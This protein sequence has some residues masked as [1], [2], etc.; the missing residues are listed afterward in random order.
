MQ[1]LQPLIAFAA[2]ARHASF[3]AAARE[4]GQAP[5]TLAKAVARLEANLGLQLF[6]R[7][8]RQVRL[9]ADGERLYQR[10]QRVLDELEELQT[11]AS[12]SRA[13]P[14][15]V[16]RVAMPVFYGKRFVLPRLAGLLR[17][18]PQLQ[19]DARLSDQY[20]DIVREGLDLAVRIGEL[21][22]SSLV[23][24]RV[25]WQSLC[26]CASP[27]YLRRAGTPRHVEDLSAHAAVLF[28]LPSSGRDR[29][30][31]LRQRGQPV[32]LQPQA[33]LRINET[34][35]VLEALRLG[36]GIAQ[37]PDNVVAEDIKAGRL[38]DLLPG[39]RPPRMPVHVVM[40]PGRLV[41]PR[42]RAAMA[43]LESLSGH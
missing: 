31:Q 37:L 22:D 11:I 24:R 18:H 30:W 5:S 12:G 6:Q 32:T 2:T 33:T 28:R 20:V 27:D 29:P 4:Q 35:G 9:T 41:A 17:Q 10:C 21:D 25:D 26:L 16:L 43:A 23:A 13:S 3:A 14:T 40:P 34:E 36:L 42:V 8:T 7:T 39:L 15:G 1:G 38:V 19:L